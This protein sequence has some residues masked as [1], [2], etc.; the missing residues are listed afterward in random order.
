[1]EILPFVYGKVAEMQE[2]TDRD[3]ESTRLTQN[4]VSLVNTMI[5]S[6]RRWGKTSL[7]K[8][9]ANQIV[10]E[11]KDIRVCMLEV[12]NVRNEEDFYLYYAQSLIKATSNRWEE[13]VE[14]AKTFLSRLLPKVTFFA[15]NQAEIS[16]GVAW[17]ELKRNPDDIID[18][19][20]TIAK[21]KGIKIIVCIDELQ[22]IGNFSDSI[23]FQ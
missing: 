6:P 20:E 2:F 17:Q 10:S 15:D 12:F 18:L 16:F 7:V 11:N 4:F 14:N 8:K 13:W 23:A 19:A 21:A 5:I 9:V 22:N 3:K 1:M